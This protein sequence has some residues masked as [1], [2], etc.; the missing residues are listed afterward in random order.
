MNFND[1]SKCFDSV[2]NYNFKTQKELENSNIL[3]LGQLKA[4]VTEF[5]IA[6]IYVHYPDDSKTDTISSCFSF[7]LLI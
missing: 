6:D 3:L 4:Y 2:I 7:L 1:V 5:P